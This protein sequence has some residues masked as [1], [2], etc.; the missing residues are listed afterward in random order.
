MTNSTMDIFLNGEL[1]GT[2][3]NVLPNA[4][5]DNMYSGQDNGI[6]GKVCNINYYND[7]IDIKQ[8]YRNYHFLKGKH[9][10]LL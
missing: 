4:S 7:T 8:I 10:P 9:I 6:N 1:V 3:E 2:H 5:Y